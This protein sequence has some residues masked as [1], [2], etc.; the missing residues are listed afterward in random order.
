MLGAL[1][2]FAIAILGFRYGQ[3]GT[4]KMVMNSERQAQALSLAQR[5]MT[6]LEIQLKN[7]TLKSIPE[8]EKGDFKDE[9]F[10]EYKWIRKLE[11]VD[12]GCFMPKQPGE[13]SQKDGI[14]ATFEKI[15]DTAVRKIKVTVEWKEGNKTR[16]QSLTQLYVRFQEF[17]S[18]L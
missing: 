6:E 5:Q 18:G 17:P 11:K 3:S 15:F 2:I 13:G 14:T 12:L 16:S 10:K 8:E 4:A 9:A 1:M 7:K